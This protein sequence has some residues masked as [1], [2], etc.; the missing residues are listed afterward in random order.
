[1]ESAV[2]GAG[3]QH[4]VTLPGSLKWLAWNSNVPLSLPEGLTHL[5]LSDV[6][7]Q[8]LILPSTLKS[9]YF[10]GDGGY[11]LPLVLPPGCTRY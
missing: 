7:Q 3:M 11:D 10:E 5:T 8:S 1:M 6:F 2:F 4:P 9:I